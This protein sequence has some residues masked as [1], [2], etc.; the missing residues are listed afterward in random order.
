[1]LEE[2][3]LVIRIQSCC[4]NP[5]TIITVVHRL[6]AAQACLAFHDQGYLCLSHNGPPHCCYLTVL[7]PGWTG[8]NYNTI[9]Y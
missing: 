3:K 9:N 6:A 1:M 2:L 7:T 8:L 4:L 5:D